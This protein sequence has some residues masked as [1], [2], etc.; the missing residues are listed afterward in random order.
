[1][2]GR[3]AYD[4]GDAPLAISSLEKASKLRPRDRDISDLL[5]R[6][7]RESVVNGSYLEKSVEHFRI[8]YEGAAQQTIGDRVAHVLEAEYPRIGG[9]LGSYPRDPITVVL[10]TNREFHDMTRSPEW[11]TG[12]FD[13]RIQVAVG[14]ALS[15]SA[16]DRVVTHELVHAVVASAAHRRVPVWLNEGLATFLE[17]KDVS[18]A[19]NA[20]R[21]AAT[22]VPLETLAGGFD[23]FD[24]QQAV[25]AYAESAIAA[26]ILCGQLGSNIG[27]FLQ[28][29]GNGRSIDDALMDFQIQPNAFHSEWRRR[30]GLR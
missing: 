3:V 18:W 5:D 22:V 19:G 9:T 7:R 15:S 24:Q 26:E 25:V 28:M 4:R 6:C 16:L 20:V 12:T 8:L 17:S 29:V 1:M 21:N 11:A 14:G 23:G 10:Y 13:G 30:V 27:S 2:L